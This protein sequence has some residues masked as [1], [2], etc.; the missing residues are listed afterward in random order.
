MQQSLPERDNLK[1]MFKLRLVKWFI[2]ALLCISPFI[3]ASFA[4]ENR[5][6]AELASLLANVSKVHVY[7]LDNRALKDSLEHLI[8]NDERIKAVR[9]KELELGEV[10]F[11]YYIDND[12]K[13]FN[14]SIPEPI[15]N[16]QKYS[17]SIVYDQQNIAI[18]E[19]YVSEAP[20]AAGGVY[21]NSAE[22]ELLNNGQVIRIGVENTDPLS[23]K[24]NDTLTGINIDYIQQLIADTPLQVEFV[25]GTFVDLLQQLER[26]ELDVV[27]GVYYHRSREKLGYF[28]QPIMKIRDFL[29]VNDNNKQ[30]RGLEDL[31]GKKVAIVNGYLSISIVQEQ[32]PDVEVITTNNLMES[33]TL[34]INNDVSA[35]IDAQLFVSSLQ[36]KNG[37]TGLKSIPVHEMP[38]KNIYFLTHKNLPQLSSIITKLQS[39][40]QSINL[41]NIIA[42]YVLST[43]SV[44]TELDTDKFIQQFSSTIILLVVLL[45]ML[46]LVAYLVNKTVSSD[47]A[48]LIFGTKGFEKF[49]LVAIALF[50]T[51][52]ILASWMILEQYKG[53]VKNKVKHDLQRSLILAEDKVSDALDLYIGTLD[54]E[55]NE[56]LVIDDI[57]AFI[58]A[59]D[60]I[61]RQSAA[62]S[63]VQSWEK[64]SRFTRASHRSLLDL[65]GQA[66]LGEKTETV[67]K[68]VAKHPL[69]FAKANEGN[70][71]LFSS[72]IC[73]DSLVEMPTY[74]CIVLLEPII[75]K[76]HNII[77]LLLDEISANELF[78]EQVY[79]ISSGTSER[80]FA[81]NWQ[82]DYLVNQ[83]ILDALSKAGRQE[84]ATKLTK[85]LYLDRPYIDV[86]EN[87]GSGNVQF[88][89][90]VV[91][92]RDFNDNDILAFYFWNANYNYG[93]VIET[94]A[95]EAYS[96]F[97][98]L[99][100]SVVLLILI[101]MSFAVPSILLTLKLGRKANENLSEAK[102]SLEVS[103]IKLEKLVTERTKKLV[104]LEEQGRSILSSVGQGLL[105]VDVNGRLLFVNDSALA[106]LG[107]SEKDLTG[108]NVLALVVTGNAEQVIAPE[109]LFY[110]TIAEGG[111]FNSDQETFYHQK[112]TSIP[113][114]YTSRAIV[115]KDT[116]KGCVVVFSDISSRLKMQNELKQAKIDAEQASRAKS[117]FLANMSHE[118]RTPM[119]AII[120]MSHLALQT[121]LD[122]KQRNYIQKVSSSAQ[123]LLGIINDILDF[124]KIEAGK[125]K[126]E[127]RKFKLDDMLSELANVIG[128]KADEKDLEIIFSL[129]A[130]LP[131]TVVGDSLRLSQILLN[132]CNNAI[133]F[134]HSGEV[135]IAVK[136]LSESES[137]VQLQFDVTDTGIG[138]TEEH[139]GKLFQ[140][141]NQ[142]DS[143]T[144]RQY[145]GTGLG[146]VICKNLVT[147]MDGEISVKSVFGQ[148]TTF[149]FQVSL[150]KGEAKEHD[151][152][153]FS[154][155]N[156][157][158]VLVVD[159]NKTALEILST[160][161]LSLRLNVVSAQSAEQA[162]KI[163]SDNKQTFD[164]I[165]SDWYMPMVDGVDFIRQAKDYYLQYLPSQALP[166]FM[167][168]TAFSWED[169]QE[170][171][172]GY[173]ANLIQAF[174]S[175]PITYSA[176]I[177]GIEYAVGFRSDLNLTPETIDEAIAETT[178]PLKGARILLVEDNEINLELAEEI[179]VSRAI[180]VTTA[181][182]GQEAVDIA[183]EEKFDGILMDCQMPIMD[184]YQATRSIRLS[185]ENMT[186]PILAMTANALVG[187]KEKALA[188]GMNDHIAKPIDIKDMFSKMAKWIQ[189]T[190]NRRLEKVNVG[191]NSNGELAEKSVVNINIPAL[192]VAKGL[193]TCQGNETLYLKLLGK[194]VAS[195]TNFH[196]S[197]MT[198]FAQGNIDEC[199]LMAHT[200]KGVAGN[201]GA[202]TIYNQA[203]E[204]ETLFAQPK[205]RGEDV[206]E[207]CQDIL[208][209]I[210]E[211]QHALQNLVNGED[212]HS[213]AGRMS[214]DELLALLQEAELYI[215]E[216]DTSA[217]EVVEKIKTGNFSNEINTLVTQ[218]VNNANAYEFDDAH[219]I[220]KRIRA[221]L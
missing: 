111:V 115:N 117:E 105:G 57:G 213:N 6:M 190:G 160:M 181:L 176:L 145:G 42:K 29:Y 205:F 4:E 155:K 127:E 19:L 84:F 133:K 119:N 188:S 106:I 166:K 128:V 179:L 88:S 102:D 39:S 41:K 212:N 165:I 90:Q 99:R 5:S 154:A 86:E 207:I 185:G 168:V 87:I 22:R 151:L 129:A 10:V 75:D 150:K 182:N 123:S 33:V 172:E 48:I 2:T 137:S 38:A 193:A 20:I 103:K 161:L 204:L 3:S 69:D 208:N 194:F 131:L 142:A 220:I 210:N 47:R 101:V 23:F 186:T 80:L 93:L 209:D 59:K 64:Y 214:N 177:K 180:D 189:V 218:L 215:L 13:I 125:L 108:I 175:K 26:G 144:T 12:K 36:E 81:T 191:I 219:Q 201:I 203:L 149:S 116:I 44:E 83:T 58:N 187:D 202:E 136:L 11:S 67:S 16:Y 216:D 164:V 169:A 107:F 40:K 198:T 91:E 200:L 92:Y 173:E 24:S 135:L 195:E 72:N 171:S 121:A 49:M 82:G 139:L 78:L 217:I 122:N 114:E 124:S 170:K 63:I 89:R 1:F 97:Q 211:I 55:L 76:D 206:A 104:N 221:Q 140:S 100:R 184:G 43:K 68:L 167:L 31:R 96:S 46:I 174:L 143:S 25:M 74:S 153:V 157:K 158:N 56:T 130:D 183:N 141:F 61:S 147:L 110:K 196:A 120:G 65:S 192:N 14:R 163:I 148:G 156:V 54:Y 109:H 30:V 50:A 73:A 35:L 8:I 146:L 85:G 27:A 34:L 178:E 70:R 17:Q 51:F 18:I 159:D 138:M 45:L 66:L 79:A 15:L 152:A 126:M 53:E 197:F 134:T 7:K 60:E 52:I 162:L 28:S 199:K 9:I 62:E 113:V 94:T 77:A 95:D 32:F 118:I 37:L 132:L 21:F 98:L 112:G 71:V